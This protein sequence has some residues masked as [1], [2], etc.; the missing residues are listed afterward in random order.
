[1]PCYRAFFSVNCGLSLI[2]IATIFELPFPQRI[3]YVGGNGWFWHRCG[4][5]ERHLLAQNAVYHSKLVYLA[6]FRRAST[7]LVFSYISKTILRKKRP[8]LRQDG[9]SPF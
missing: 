9:M 5:P 1:M 7:F 6:V 2:F 3:R 8:M 4:R